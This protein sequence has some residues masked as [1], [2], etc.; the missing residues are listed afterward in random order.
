[1]NMDCRDNDRSVM[2]EESGKTT[3]SRTRSAHGSD[4]TEEEIVRWEQSQLLTDAKFS[5]ESCFS[6]VIVFL[7]MQHN[8]MF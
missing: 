3:L 4:H 8:N 1:M 2:K 6:C 5:S 7:Q